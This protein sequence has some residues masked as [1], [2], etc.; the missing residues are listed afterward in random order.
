[1]NDEYKIIPDGYDLPRPETTN[2]YT[3]LEIEGV[4]MSLDFL[5]RALYPGSKQEDLKSTRHGTNGLSRL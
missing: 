1:M 2:D 4:P 3:L 5:Q